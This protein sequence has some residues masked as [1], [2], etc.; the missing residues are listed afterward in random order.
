MK[1]EMLI[2]GVIDMDEDKFNNEDELTMENVLKDI[3]S[4]AISF[5][6]VEVVKVVVDGEELDK[7]DCEMI[8]D[9]ILEVVQ[10][11]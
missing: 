5:E 1:L 4:G 8:S 6:I 11:N 10:Q 7:E 2:R 3:E 9:A